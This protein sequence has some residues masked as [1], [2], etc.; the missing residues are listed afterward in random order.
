MALQAQPELSTV[1][2]VTAKLNRSVCGDRSSAAE[3]IRNA[4]GRHADIQP[5]AY[6][7]SDGGP[8]SLP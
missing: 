5:Q 6:L 2:K 3:H 7:H 4:A 1:G 8:P